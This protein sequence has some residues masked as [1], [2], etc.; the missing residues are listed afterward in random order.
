MKRPIIW[1]KDNLRNM[2]V[3][4]IKRRAAIQRAQED[5]DRLQ[6]D[7]SRL[8]A[9]IIEAELRGIDGFDADKFGQKKSSVAKP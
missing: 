4:L 3:G 6:S 9:Q 8:D 7:I 1:H 5:F 2:E